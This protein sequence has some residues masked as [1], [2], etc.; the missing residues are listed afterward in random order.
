MAGRFLQIV[1]R[2]NGSQQPRFGVSV[3]SRLGSAVKRNRIKRWIREAIRKNKRSIK[4]GVDLVVHPKPNV[5]TG[6]QRI[7]ERELQ[8]LLTSVNRKSDV[9]I[10][11][12]SHTDRPEA[13]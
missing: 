10:L 6:E 1:Y 2:P 13:L 12:Q 9:A 3:G 8:Y 7:I 11:H 4:F 5:L